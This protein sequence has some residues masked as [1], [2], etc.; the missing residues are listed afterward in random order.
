V[1]TPLVIVG[2]TASGKTLLSLNMA[3]RLHGEIISADSRQVYKYLTIGTSKPS[4]E[5][6]ATAPHHFVDILDPKEVYSAGLFARQAMEKVEAVISGGRTPIVVGGSGLYIKAVV[7]GIFDGPAAQPEIRRRLEQRLK[8]EGVESLTRELERVDQ[9]TAAAM[10]AEPKPRRLIRALEVYY[11]TGKPLSAHHG[12]QTRTARFSW[13]QV[14][15][16]WNRPD[17]YKRIDQRVDRMFE[18]GLLEEVNWLKENGYDSRLNSLNTVGYK[19]VFDHLQ[20]TLNLADCI[21]LVKRNTRRFAKRQ[22]TWFRADK[23]IR[24]IPV[25]GEPEWGTIAD[26]T[27]DLY[28]K[29]SLPS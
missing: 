28:R 12:A 3:H 25:R 13:I 6:R 18:A 22:L 11:A 19:E 4:E 24:W 21:D 16:D 7:D 27:E 17:L 2:P 23:R 8:E 1:N 9:G 5:D 29:E 20:G 14:G 15:L 10:K 26:R